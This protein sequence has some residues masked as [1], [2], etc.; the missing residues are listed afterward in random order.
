[1]P[2]LSP[3]LSLNYRG[4][5]TSLKSGDIVRIERKSGKMSIVR[6]DELLIWRNPLLGTDRTEWPIIS[7]DSQGWVLVAFMCASAGLSCDPV[8][9]GPDYFAYLMTVAGG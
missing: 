9:R 6:G 2:G 5:H 7:A 3:F 4:Q 1:M 8:D